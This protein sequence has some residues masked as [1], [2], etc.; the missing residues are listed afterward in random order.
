MKKILVLNG[1]NLNM[2]GVR[3]PA[4]YGTASLEDINQELAELGGTLGVDVEFYQSNIEGELI[5]KLHTTDANGIVFNAGAYT[6]YSIALRD[7]IAA[8]KRP[9]V[10]V[11]L[12]NVHAR[13][14][15]RHQSVLAPVCVGQISGFGKDSYKLAMI[16]LKEK[17]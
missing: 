13:E 12:S 16:G 10:E 9:V 15:F 5:N 2:L 3:E 14:E 6:H 4:V 7:A 11:H 17:L 8:I 1:P